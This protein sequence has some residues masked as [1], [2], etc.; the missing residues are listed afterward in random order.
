ML[1]ATIAEDEALNRL[2]VEAQLL[3]LMTIPHLDRDGL[4]SGNPRV[5]FGKVCPLRDEFRDRMLSYI[6]EWIDQGLVVRY[7]AGGPVLFFRNFRKHQTGLEYG[8]DRASRFAPPPD[9]IRTPEGLAPADPF[10]AM[11]LASAFDVRS[12]YRRALLEHAAAGGADVATLQPA[13][14]DV[15]AKSSRS[16][17]D[18][19]APKIDIRE[20]SD[21]DDSQPD[22]PSHPRFGEGGDARG[23]TPAP[24]RA[25]ADDAVL[26]NF[27]LALID[28]VFGP[29]TWD[30]AP[31]YVDRLD[32]DGL[33]RLMGWLWKCL[34]RPTW[35]ESIGVGFVRSMMDKGAAAGLTPGERQ[36][37]LDALESYA[38]DPG[39]V[40]FGAGILK[41]LEPAFDDEIG[42]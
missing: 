4:I 13:C 40:L 38:T 23:G 29:T 19:I 5:L 9:W 21:V 14:R 26:R 10:L 2:S 35:S 33:L 16:P 22:I 27:D 41:V 15:I 30:G 32:Y 36:G 24:G 37:M 8:R 42:Y 28:D 20:V 6:N 18:N 3:F 1:S 11:T 34:V 7:D 25:A 17:R 39:S 12:A 31:G